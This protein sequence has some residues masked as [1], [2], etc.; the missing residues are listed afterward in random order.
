MLSHYPVLPLWKVTMRVWDSLSLPLCLCLS[1][2]TGP[3]TSWVC[4]HWSLEMGSVS[5]GLK[6]GSELGDPAGSSSPLMPAC[7]KDESPASTLPLKSFSCS[8]NVICILLYTQD[9]QFA[10]RQIHQGQP[11]PRRR[12]MCLSLYLN[13]MI[14]V[15]LLARSGK[16]RVHS[17]LISIL[18]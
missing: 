17:S 9:G 8:H 12:F 4:H 3:D 13:L 15:S 14:T 6:C 16:K 18:T 2:S 11:P 7:G 10:G 5:R 1:A